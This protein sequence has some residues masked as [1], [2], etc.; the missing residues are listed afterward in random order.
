MEESN[1]PVVTMELIL[2]TF[3][4]KAAA[5]KPDAAALTSS[6]IFSKQS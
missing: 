3:S 1:I 2:S 6:M 5:P 4:K